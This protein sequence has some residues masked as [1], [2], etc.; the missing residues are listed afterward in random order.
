MSPSL[1][2]L[3]RPTEPVAISAT[4]R[5]AICTP[6]EAKELAES[7]AGMEPWSRY[8]FPAPA[9]ETYLAGEEPGAP[10]YTIRNEGRLAGALGLR[11][12]WLRGPYIQFLGI[13]PGFQGSGAGRAILASLSREAA[14]CGVRNLW[15]AASSFNTRA[16]RFYERAGF[17]RAG[18]LEGLVQDGF[19][20]ILL[21]KRL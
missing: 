12:N 3:A 21:R 18:V 9:L 8:P 20:E 4:L 15:V 14:A 1:L 13:L 11:L 7:F 19:D 10:R 16:L 5:A 6:Q 2:D 17:A